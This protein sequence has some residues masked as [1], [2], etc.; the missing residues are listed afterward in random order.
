MERLKHTFQVETLYEEVYRDDEASEP[1]L[2]LNIH[3]MDFTDDDQKIALES[4]RRRF[5]KTLREG[6]EAS[7]GSLVKLKIPA[8]AIKQIS[9]VNIDK[10]EIEQKAAAYDEASKV[11]EAEPVEEASAV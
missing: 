1:R 4:A 9:I 5:S 11:Q 2:R 10:F 3:K 7:Y 6:L 8:S